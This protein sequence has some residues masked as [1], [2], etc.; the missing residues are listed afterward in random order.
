MAH[1]RIGIVGLAAGFGGAILAL[2]GD[3]L[4]WRWLLFAAIPI[5]AG[6][7]LAIWWYIVTGWIAAWRKGVSGK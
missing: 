5:V 3:W 1:G 7:I 6:G 2:I 4:E